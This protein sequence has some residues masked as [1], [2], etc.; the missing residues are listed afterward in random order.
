M[1]RAATHPVDEPTLNQSGSTITLK[2]T[3]PIPYIQPDTTP[4]TVQAK[5]V[6]RHF[7]THPNK[8]RPEAVVKLSA[9][10]NPS[11]FADAGLY[12]V[13]A[14]TLIIEKIPKKIPDRAALVAFE[15]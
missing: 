5:R 11:Q 2:S 4:N 3:A 1:I 7:L 13:F 6:G 15:L 9:P 8:M 14:I 12:T 10:V